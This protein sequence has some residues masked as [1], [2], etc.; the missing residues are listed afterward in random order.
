[1]EFASSAA[2]GDVLHKHVWFGIVLAAA[3]SVLYPATEASAQWVTV[4]P[5]DG[6]F[7]AVLP[8]RAEFKRLPAKPK[9]D[10]RV[11]LVH[12]AKRFFPIGVTDYDAHIDAERELELDV[13]NFLASDG[14]RSKRRRG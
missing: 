5:A 14:A 3:L 2:G 11:W 4:A 10:T 12:D 13:K 1:V 8:G 6:G 7:S 9:V